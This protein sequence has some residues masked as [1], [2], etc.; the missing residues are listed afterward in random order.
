MPSAETQRFERRVALFILAVTAWRIVTLAFDQT[1]LWVDEAQY[2]LWGKNLDWGY[3]SKPPLIAFWLA[4][5]TELAGS[6]DKF[7]IRVTG[8]LLHAAT[9][10]LIWRAAQ[11]LQYE[12]LRR[13]LCDQLLLP[14]L[15][16][17]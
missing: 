15:R 16:Q 4:G 8:S 1:E 9:A 17:L 12:L 11:R 7:W 3:F 5:V 13:R 10:L 14:W 2:W 6:D